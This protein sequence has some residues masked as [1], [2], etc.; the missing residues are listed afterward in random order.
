MNLIN[1]LHGLPAPT[2]SGS[3]KLRRGLF[4]PD[5]DSQGDSGAGQDFGDGLLKGFMLIP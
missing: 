1:F 3:A 4:D 2:E 5:Y